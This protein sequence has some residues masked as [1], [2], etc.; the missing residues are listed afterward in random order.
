VTKY[1]TKF[2][3]DNYMEAAF[4]NVE[5]EVYRVESEEAAMYF[6]GHVEEVN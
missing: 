6:N 3:I 2:D 4:R 5:N 1:F